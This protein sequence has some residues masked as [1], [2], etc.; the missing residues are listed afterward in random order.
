MAKIVSPPP[1]LA[2]LYKCQDCGNKLSLLKAILRKKCPACGGSRL[3]LSVGML[4]HDPRG[5]IVN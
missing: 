1:R 5:V 2:V 4:E 3:K